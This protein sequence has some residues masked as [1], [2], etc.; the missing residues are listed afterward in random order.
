MKYAMTIVACCL[1]TACG[2][3]EDSADT[4]EEAACDEETE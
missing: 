2:D 1:L 3:K 4:G